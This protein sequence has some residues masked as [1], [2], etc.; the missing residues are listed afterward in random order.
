M[1]EIP[2][3]DG[4][5]ESMHGLLIG[6]LRAHVA[7]VYSPPRVTARA[8]RFGLRAGFAMDLLTY[9]ENG[10][11]WDFDDPEQRRKCKER[12]RKECPYLLNGSPMCTIFNV[13]QNLNE[14]RLGRKKWAELWAYGLRH[15][16]FTL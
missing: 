10:K 16:L 3:S 5:D 13:I 1:A 11:A 9:D 2:D 8:S 4:D 12:L 7:E 15:L 6:M 14:E